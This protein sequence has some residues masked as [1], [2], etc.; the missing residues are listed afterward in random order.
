MLRPSAVC[1]PAVTAEQKKVKSVRIYP[2][3]AH[4]R[5]TAGPLSAPLSLCVRACVFVCWCICALCGQR[6]PQT[7]AVL[8]DLMRRAGLPW[9][10]QA[11]SLSHRHTHTSCSTCPAYS[12]PPSQSPPKSHRL[13]ETHTALLESH[14]ENMR[15]EK[16]RPIPDVSTFLHFYNLSACLCGIWGHFERMGSENANV[17]PR[18]CL[19]SCLASKCGSVLMMHLLVSNDSGHMVTPRAAGPFD[20]TEHAHANT[21]LKMPDIS[22]S[23]CAH[24]PFH[25]LPPAHTRA[26]SH[27]DMYRAAVHSGPLW[28]CGGWF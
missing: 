16:I 14:G 21:F 22:T 28:C 27:T 10:G 11:L 9:P 25:V 3:A 24:T 20:V 1:S 12:P 19:V 8:P 17:R 2:L 13:V 18:S 4:H 6:R 23:A 15:M 7:R 26:H 5:S